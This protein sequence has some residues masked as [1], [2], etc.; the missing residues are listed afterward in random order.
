MICSKNYSE[1]TKTGFITSNMPFGTS[2]FKFST[3]FIKFTQWCDF[4]LR[5]KQCRFYMDMDRGYGLYCCG[6]WIQTYK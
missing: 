2:P 3:S 6:F 1:K 4:G 5:G